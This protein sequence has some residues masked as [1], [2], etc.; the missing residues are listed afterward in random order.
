MARIFAVREP[1]PGAKPELKRLA[2][3]MVDGETARPGD[4]AQAL[5]DLGATICTP[6][7]PQCLL[8]PVNEFCD[9]YALGIAADLPMRIAKTAKPQKH[10]YVYW[11]T[12]PDGRVLFE[13]RSEKGLLGGTIGL[14]TSLWP[15]ANEA[16]THLEFVTRE[17]IDNLV[18]RHGFTHFD[19]DLHGVRLDLPSD[20]LP[21][22]GD[23]FWVRLAEAKK[24]GI[25]TLF[26]KALKQFI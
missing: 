16:R 19:L 7:S 26:K 3:I 12:A 17:N 5:M 6:S 11:I 25:P 2:G 1:V 15:M 23:Y 8:C 18:V 4:Y 21:A 9:A 24:L 20:A 22:V 13:R 14:P 10:G